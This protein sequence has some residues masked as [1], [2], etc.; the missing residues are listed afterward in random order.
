MDKHFVLALFH[1]LII[2]PFLLY[3]GMYR[4]STH[5]WAYRALLV[6]GVI[7]LLYHG[8]KLVSRLIM[9]S[10]YAYINAIHV[11]VAPLLLYIGY[12]RQETPRAAYELLLM[13]AFG[14]LGYHTFSLVKILQ[15]QE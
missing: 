10:D 2:V 6:I 11:L 9:R 8:S 3:V 12:H 1:I 15:I 5:P 14:A 13:L 4:A 7:L